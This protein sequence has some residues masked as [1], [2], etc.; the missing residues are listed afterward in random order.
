MSYTLWTF[1]GFMVFIVLVGF[2]Y[3]IKDFTKR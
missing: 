3:T 1:E 2:Y